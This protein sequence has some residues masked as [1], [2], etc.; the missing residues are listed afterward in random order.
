MYLQPR[1]CLTGLA[2]ETPL[3]SSA[4]ATWEALLRGKSAVRPFR[5]ED[6]PGRELGTFSAAP[7]SQ[8]DA[9]YGDVDPNLAASCRVAEAAWQDAGL[10]ALQV[11]ATRVGCCFGSSKGGLP[12]IHGWYAGSRNSQLAPTILDFSPSGPCSAVV[13]RLNIQGPSSAVATACSTGLTSVMTAVRWLQQDLCDVVLAG[14]VDVSL[15]PSVAAAFRRLGVLSRCN[16]ESA[17]RPCDVSRDGFVIGEGAACLVFE[18][19]DFARAR[20]RMPLAHWGGAQ[21]LTDPA[22]LTRGDATGETLRELLR[23]MNDPDLPPPDAIS[24]HATGTRLNDPSETQAIRQTWSDK[25]DQMAVYGVKGA[26]GH[27]LGAAGTVELGLAALTLRHGQIPATVHCQNPDPACPVPVRDHSQERRLR[28]T[29][30]ISLGFG[31]HLAAVRLWS[32]DA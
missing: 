8:R 4:T 10:S 5:F 12:T 15:Q 28:S 18:R 16:N 9:A 20:G 11:D 32:P 17:C 27:L 23:R 14:S 22:G 2:L 24:L 30:K 19:D 25:V 26:I 13:D 3:G 7:A 21:S 6:G 31:G 1:I 29:L